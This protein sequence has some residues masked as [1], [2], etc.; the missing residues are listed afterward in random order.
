MRGAETSRVKAT[1]A[2]EREGSLADAFRNG[3]AAARSLGFE[4]HLRP[5]LEGDPGVWTCELRKGGTPVPDGFGLGK[6]SSEA[7]RVGALFEA[8]E[9]YVSEKD[10][11]DTGLV[12]NV[13]AHS[14][15]GGDGPLQRDQAVQL[16]REL[17]DE[18]LACLEYE[19]LGSGA[20]VL[21][22]LFLSS[23]GYVDADASFRTAL[24]DTFDYTVV[25]RY[26]SNNG[27]ASGVT[28]LEATVHA[29]NEVVERDAFSLLLLGQFLH[30]RRRPLRLVDRRTLPDGLAKL[31][32]AADDVTGQTVH[33]IDM[34]TDISVP[35]FLAYVPPEKGE[36]ARVRGCGASLSSEYAAYRALTELVQGQTAVQLENTQDDFPALKLARPDNTLPYPAIHACR[37]ADLTAFLPKADLVAFAATTS[38]ETPEAHLGELLRRLFDKGYPVLRRKIA[39]PEGLAVVNTLVPGLERFMFVTDGVLVIPGHRGRQF[40]AS[41]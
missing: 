25:G 28:A 22:P 26:S 9:H 40:L 11:L 41:Q 38:P 20:E 31:A 37:Q 30:R 13:R 6:G 1:Q 34:T 5:V 14:I 39:T 16:L 33:L 23:P 21:V 36:P 8:L 12:R 29:L 17:D 32:A 10:F 18:P 15:A 19:D 3:I 35:V 2:G 4:A 27:F 7:A 24:G